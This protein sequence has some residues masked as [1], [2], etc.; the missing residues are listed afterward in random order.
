MA[1]IIIFGVA[2]NAV[3]DRLVEAEAD[4]IRVRRAEG[5]HAVLRGYAE[6]RY[7]AKSWAR[8][9]RAVARIEASASQENDMLRRGLD[10][11]YVV[12]SL[13]KGSAEYIYATLYCGRG[14]AENLIKQHKGSLHESALSVRHLEHAP[15]RLAATPPG[16]VRS[17][18]SHGFGLGPIK[19]RM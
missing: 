10:I 7:A 5:Q 14:Q 6:T 9:R 8:E 17:L 12:T 13:D 18:G 15:N 4:D 2:G 19:S 3:L 11:R 1:S 16:A